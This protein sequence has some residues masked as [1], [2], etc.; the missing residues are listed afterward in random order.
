MSNSG[1]QG[2]MADFNPR[3]YVRHDPNPGLPGS[4]PGN[5]NPRAYVRH[6]V[7]ILVGIV[8]L[9]ISIHVPT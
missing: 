4:G 8:R 2:T 6:D 3:A 5:F 9:S 7:S 1:I